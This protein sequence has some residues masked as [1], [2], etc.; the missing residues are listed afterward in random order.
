MVGL[1][2]TDDILNT[3]AM[4]CSSD[5]GRGDPLKFRETIPSSRR[6]IFESDA[7]AKVSDCLGCHLTEC[8]PS[9]NV[10]GEIQRSR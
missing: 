8:N 5:W 10:P 9:P 6:K 1:G 4:R 3:C 2:L 7:T